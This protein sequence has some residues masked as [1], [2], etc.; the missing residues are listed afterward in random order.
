MYFQLGG[1]KK[2]KKKKE[3]LNTASRPIRD[4]L[5][6]IWMSSDYKRKKKKELKHLFVLWNL[7]TF[8]SNRRE[9]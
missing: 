8:N 5:L 3:A 2:K 9:P 7:Y 1:K 6:Y 4:A